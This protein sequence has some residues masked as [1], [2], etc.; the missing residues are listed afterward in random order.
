MYR[1]NLLVETAESERFRKRAGRSRHGALAALLHPVTIVGAA[2]AIASAAVVINKDRAASRHYD[3]LLEEVRV[4]LRDSTNL[5]EG[6][7]V[8]DVYQKSRRRVEDIVS[9]LQELDQG[10]YIWPHLF[11]QFAAAIIQDQI[12]LVRWHEI[13]SSGSEGGR[14]NGPVRFQLE[15]MAANNDA[16]A[17]FMEALE[18]SPFI[19]SVIFKGTSAE[20]IQNT[21]VVRF[22]LEAQ[23]E[24]P[25]ATLLELE[26]ITPNSRS[27]RTSNSLL[28]ADVPLLPEPL[29]VDI[30]TP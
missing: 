28:P 30:P 22:T 14:A 3:T 7:Y 29:E 17:K 15:G 8:A 1:V 11:D 23:T 26:V 6:I 13:A 25:D 27:R 18:A 19:T 21:D 12:W 4:G 2:I 24:Q 9:L 5:H 16:V 10:R 20:Q